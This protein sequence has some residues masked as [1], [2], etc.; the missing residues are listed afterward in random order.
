MRRGLAARIRKVELKKIWVCSFPGELFDKIGLR[1]KYRGEPWEEPYKHHIVP[2]RNVDALPHMERYMQGFPVSSD[3]FPEASAVYSKALFPNGRPVSMAGIAYI[4]NAQIERVFRVFD[5][6]PGGMAPYPIYEG[7]EKTPISEPW[8]ILGLGAQKR[9]LLPERC[10]KIRTIVEGKAGKPS[11]YRM[12]AARRDDD[13]SF[14]ADALAGAD[15]WA[16]EG[17]QNALMM[18]EAL[19]NRI[20]KAGLGDVFQIRS[21]LVVE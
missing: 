12:W 9:S 20:I 14:S 18:S 6:G 7:D 13:L 3:L 8:W 11:I 17:L 16:E 10:A 19:G 5:I 2:Q 21:A 15:L 4:V 1:H